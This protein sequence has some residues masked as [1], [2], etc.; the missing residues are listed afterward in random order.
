VLYIFAAFLVFTGVKMLFTVDKEYDVST[1]PVLRLL[2]SK[3]PVT[4][5]LHG[6]RFFA[7][8]PHPV[9]GRSVL[10]VTPLFL[11]LVTVEAADVIFAVDSIPAIFAVTDDPFIVLTSNVF[12]ILGLRA[13]YFL[14]A[15]G[16]DRLHLL[17]YG[18]AVILGFVGLKMLGTAIPCDGHGMFCH[19]GH[20]AVP[21]WLS[22]VVI[23]GVLALTALLS[24]KIS[25]K[26]QAKIEDTIADTIDDRIDEPG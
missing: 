14:V 12:A 11:A 4:D 21:I 25:P 6:D 26:D 10:Y 15:G 9:T 7:R 2:R 5:R 20:V 1:N 13:L 17:K 16:M 24:F 8:L 18:L 23:I 19:E 22:L 3:F